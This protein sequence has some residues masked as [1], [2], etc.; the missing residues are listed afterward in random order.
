[1][2]QRTIIVGG[3]IAGLSAAI[4]LR[5]VGHDVRLFEQASE[6][7]P[8]GAA[9]SLWGNAL[10][11]LD[12]LGCGDAVRE[13]SAPIDRL[14]STTR[15]GRPLFGP[16]DISV[17]DS[18]L[19][20]RADLQAILMRSADDD[21]VSLDTRIENIEQSQNGVIVT[22]AD[23][24]S[25]AA[26]LL[27]LADGIHSK[28]A[29]DLIGNPARYAGYRGFLGLADGFADDGEAMN[30]EIWHGRERAGLFD[31]TGGQR[32][33]FFIYS[34]L[35]DGEMTHDALDETILNWPE[36][37]RQAVLRT[38][39]DRRISGAIHARSVPKRL[40]RGR[41]IAIGDAAHAMEPNLGQGAC[42]GIED[43]EALARWANTYAPEYLLSAMERERLPRIAHYMKASARIGWMAHRASPLAR[44]AIEGVMRATPAAM[45]RWQI[46]REIA[47]PEALRPAAPVD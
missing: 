24:A 1:M 38:P 8:L 21:I 36:R 45:E 6:I 22:T 30:E 17:N 9:I 5:R 16:V 15:G 32:Y 4:G 10:A 37:V 19:V 3:G 39:H 11:A 47:V 25:H 35:E 33:W 43:A 41:V 27:V 18:W 23:G 34:A 28:H 29:T 7:R 20:R 12:R 42:Q 40:G 2:V 26:D 31:A 13:A 44:R 46:A 14:R